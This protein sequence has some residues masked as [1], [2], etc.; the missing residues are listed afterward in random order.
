M[1]WRCAKCKSDKKVGNI[2]PLITPDASQVFTFGDAAFNAFM[3][4]FRAE[5]RENFK[6][7]SEDIKNLREDLALEVKALQTDVETLKKQN[8]EKDCIIETLSIHINKLDQYGRN[9]N[10]ELVNVQE[11][12]GEDVTNLVL[13][14]ANVLD[15]ELAESDIEA[16]HRIPY[17]DVTKTSRIIVQ[18]S[19]RKKREEFLEKR[20]SVLSSNLLTGGVSVAGE[21]RV[22]INENLNTYY[23]ELLWKAK[24]KSKSVGFKFVWFVSGKIF[25]KKDESARQVIKIVSFADLAKIR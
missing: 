19:S 24:E 14:L 12:P 7:I 11:L 20:R 18:L 13:K 10:I 5:S 6:A 22:Y 2:T 25:V 4:E 3:G 17:R 23:K 15:I 9:K 21:K 1:A 16:A 8:I